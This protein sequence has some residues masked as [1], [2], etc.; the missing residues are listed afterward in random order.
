MESASR[1]FKGM[2]KAL[3]KAGIQVVLDVVYNHTGEMNDELPNLCSMR[4][5]DNKTYYMTAGALSTC[6]C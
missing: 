4:G 5:I 3:H 2:V 1:E 6:K